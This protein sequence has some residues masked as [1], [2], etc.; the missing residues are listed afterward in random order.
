MIRG[1]IVASCS[2]ALPTLCE[3]RHAREQRVPSGGD[4]VARCGSS[5]VTALVT[6]ASA[7]P[8]RRRLQGRHGQRRRRRPDLRHWASLP[9]CPPN[10]VARTEPYRR[11]KQQERRIAPHSDAHLLPS[12]GGE[13][14]RIVE[15]GLG[16]EKAH[17]RRRGK[18]FFSRRTPRSARRGSARCL[19]D[20]WPQ[21]R[22]EGLVIVHAR[23]AAWEL[24]RVCSSCL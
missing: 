8:V 20:G 9:A 6:S 5:F 2:R 17:A 3:C 16:L 1:T 13:P 21:A 22:R 4:S 14:A 19:E 10:T 7:P 15:P 12:R 11:A 24:H 18:Q 23:M